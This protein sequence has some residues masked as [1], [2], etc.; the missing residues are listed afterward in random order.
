MPLP[1]EQV[2]DLARHMDTLGAQN[3]TVMDISV[4]TDWGSYVLIASFSSSRQGLGLLAEACTWLREHDAQIKVSDQDPENF[5]FVCD[6]GDVIVHL[7]KEDMRDYYSLE[8]LW[9][10]VQVIYP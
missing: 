8:T 4:Q 7:F 9:K 2:I 3:V 5:W 6:A 1:K 10:E